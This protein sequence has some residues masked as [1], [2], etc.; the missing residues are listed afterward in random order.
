MGF[1]LYSHLHEGCVIEKG[2]QHHRHYMVGDDI[3]WYTYFLKQQGHKD[4]ELELTHMQIDER[5]ADKLVIKEK[6]DTTT[7]YIIS[8]ELGPY[9][10]SAINNNAVYLDTVF[11]SLTFK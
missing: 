10:F 2:I 8:T 5:D 3:Q 7:I 11:S 6:K 4:F 9:R 1:R